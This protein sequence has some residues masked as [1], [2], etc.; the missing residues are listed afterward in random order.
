VLQGSKTDPPLCPQGREQAIELGK[1]LESREFNAVYCSPQLRAV[2][3]AQLITATTASPVY[4]RRQLR[5]ANFGLWEGKTYQEIQDHDSNNYNLFL[6][7]P[8]IYGYPAGDNLYDVQARVMPL[9]YEVA[10]AHLGDRVLVVTHKQPC[11]VILAKIMDVSLKRIREIDVDNCKVS[12]LRYTET[13]FIL[14]G[15]DQDA[16]SF[17]VPEDPL[18]ERGDDTPGCPGPNHTEHL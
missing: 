14:E 7:D 4:I 15:L 3:T 17:D 6:S 13:G 10:N 18:G 1:A 11:R 16:L 2:E 12:I 9:I 8:S 5:E